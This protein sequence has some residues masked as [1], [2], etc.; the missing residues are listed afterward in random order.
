MNNNAIAQ[1]SLAEIKFVKTRSVCQAIVEMPIEH[2]GRFI[3]MFGVPVP[4][5]EIP[6]AIARLN[7][8]AVTS[9]TEEHSTPSAVVKGS[10]TP[11]R[12]LED[13]PPSQQAGML[14]HDSEF[15]VFLM[16]QYAEAWDETQSA[17]LDQTRNVPADRLKATSKHWARTVI[18]L[19]RISTRLRRQ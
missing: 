16:H 2:A 3:E 10:D 13:M 12:K 17:L 18:A 7:E 4:G 6:V 5:A 9:E 19:L 1:G 8:G 15:C 14:C 11:R